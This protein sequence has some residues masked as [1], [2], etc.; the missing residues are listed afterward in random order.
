[1]TPDLEAKMTAATVTIATLQHRW[2]KPSPFR[3]YAEYCRALAEAHRVR[4]AVWEDAVNYMCQN[5]N[6]TP[7]GILFAAVCQAREH[8]R[9][10]A[11]EYD[12]EAKRAE[13]AAAEQAT[14][15]EAA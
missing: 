13:R 1:M 11:Y 9:S 2:T 8:D 6:T 15:L 5:P 4:L 14:R 10:T 12:S 3:S 7:G